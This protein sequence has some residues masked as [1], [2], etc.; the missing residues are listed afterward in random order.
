MPIDIKSFQ[1]WMRHQGLAKVFFCFVFNIR[2]PKNFC[3]ELNKR[4]IYAEKKK[5]IVSKEPSVFKTLPMRSIFSSAKL[6]R[7]KKNC[8]K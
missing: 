3:L 1:A 8:Y 5:Q 2:R 6:L 7:S 4:N